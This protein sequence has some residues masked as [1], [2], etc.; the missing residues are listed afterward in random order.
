MQKPGRVL[1]LAA[2]AACIA[3]LSGC[4][5]DNSPRADF[6]ATPEFGYPP[7]TVTFNASASSSPNGPIISYTWDLG[8]DSTADGVTPTHTYAEKGLYDVTL[9]V[10]D[11]TGA[12]SE[13][14]KSIQALN[15]APIAR[16]KTNVYSTGVRQPVWFD[17]SDAEDPDGEIVEYLW[18]FGDGETG[19]G[20]LVEHEYTSA[21][22]RGWRPAITLTVVDEDDASDFVTH[23]IV[24]TG[25]DACGG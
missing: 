12:T 19:E 2:V 8:D 18:D 10:R 23:E 16:F 13:R 25:C 9:E 4:F 21:H 15:R 3:G 5:I 22:G 11:S 24:V 1:V 6:T 14:T 17:A 20:V 7:L